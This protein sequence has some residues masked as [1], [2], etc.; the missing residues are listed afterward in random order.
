[1]KTIDELRNLDANDESLKKWKQ[2]LGIMTVPA[3]PKGE[4]QKVVI[5]SFAIAV[6]GKPDTV[7]DISSK[8]KIESLK[9]RVI[10]VKEG[11][12]YDLK[13]N[14]RIQHDIALGLQYNQIIQKDGEQVDT[15]E[16]MIGSYAPRSQPYNFTISMNSVPSGPEN[17]G[18]YQINSKFFDDDKATHLE[19]SWQVRISRDWS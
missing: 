8:E 7:L 12:N 15:M 16:Q 13:I 17:Y 18:I 10:V 14:F 6:H 9:N 19:F 2:S 1:K 3:G 11:I 4:P 5:T